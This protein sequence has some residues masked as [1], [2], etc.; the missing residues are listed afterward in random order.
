MNA[1]TGRGDC[2]GI[3]DEGNDSQDVEILG[4]MVG[5]W[6]KGARVINPL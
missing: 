4:E 3:E 6:G 5:L 1:I 2:S